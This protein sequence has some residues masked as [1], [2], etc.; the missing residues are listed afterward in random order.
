MV[1]DSATQTIAVR[2]TESAT[3]TPIQTRDSEV[4]E[5]VAPTFEVPQAP[6]VNSPPRTE[7][8]AQS[9][10]NIEHHVDVA[11]AYRQ[12][13]DAAMD[14][15]EPASPP[16]TPLTV[17]SSPFSEYFPDHY[18][19]QDVEDL[20][21]AFRSLRID[22]VVDD[23]PVEDSAPVKDNA[24]V[25]NVQS[26]QAAR[27][28]SPE[29]TPMPDAPVPETPLPEAPVQEAPMPDAPDNSADR[30]EEID[31]TEFQQDQSVSM[32]HEDTAP[33]AFG[34]EHDN[35]QDS[36]TANLGYDAAVASGPSGSQQA[37]QANLGPELAEDFVCDI[38][39][40]GLPSDDFDY[41]AVV[42]P[43]PSETQ[44]SGAA[45]T[46]TDGFQ[47]DSSARA[48]AS[49]S[50]DQPASVDH[51]NTI[52]QLASIGQ[53]DTSS[54]FPA[55][56]NPAPTMTTTQQR[57]MDSSGAS[58]SHAPLGGR[59]VAPIRRRF[60]QQT[61][62]PVPLPLPSTRVPT[63]PPLA[64]P[65]ANP[66][67][68]GHDEEG[69]IVLPSGSRG[70]LGQVGQTTIAGGTG[71]TLQVPVSSASQQQAPA[72]AQPAQAQAAQTISQQQGY[73]PNEVNFGDDDL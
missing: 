44:L 68:F 73:N 60:G 22:D 2:T 41:D 14:L 26:N 12:A 49:A 59:R 71:L 35:I 19:P 67:C 10:Q 45:N 11:P 61:A 9:S 52:D 3:E 4:Q 69:D 36:G 54:P 23:V 55:T 39:D 57:T 33:S 8:G 15:D 64:P 72:Q 40:T 37:G 21:L 1:T 24:P 32:N 70:V 13:T 48:L 47:F 17:P 30:S 58:S 20:E 66:L 65:S 50:S 51:L 5:S 53:P 63:P 28:P 38:V 16:L 34:L 7:L 31:Q 29:N 46:I 27:S 42:V 62:P 18:D 56:D 6:V 25:N 43:G